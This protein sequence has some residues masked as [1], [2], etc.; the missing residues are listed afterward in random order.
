MITNISFVGPLRVGDFESEFVSMNDRL[1]SEVRI[2]E[3]D[4]FEDSGSGS[5]VSSVGTGKVAYLNLLK[6]MELFFA[7]SFLTEFYGGGIRIS[8][9]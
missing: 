4:E 8:L 1:S 6:V 9:I 7:L 5:S 3:L 2:S